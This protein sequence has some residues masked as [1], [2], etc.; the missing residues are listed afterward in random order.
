MLSKC[1]LSSAVGWGVH[2]TVHSSLVQ[3]YADK[4]LNSTARVQGFPLNAKWAK[5]FPQSES[6]CVCWNVLIQQKTSF[7]PERTS[8]TQKADQ[9][10]NIPKMLPQNSCMMLRSIIT[11]Q[12][13]RETHSL[14]Q[15]SY[16]CTLGSEGCE[17]TQVKSITEDKS[18]NK[19]TF[20]TQCVSC[21]GMRT[22][23]ML[24]S[25]KKTGEIFSCEPSFRNRVNLY[26]N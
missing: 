9:M 20:Q 11:T 23:G 24:W 10:K 4:P 18:I 7:P 14:L 13:K 16:W 3:A 6:V 26:L 22:S 17:C 2:E 5:T 12:E 25:W 21:P 19:R 8:H 15:T 1:T